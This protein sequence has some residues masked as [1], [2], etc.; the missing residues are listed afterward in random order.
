M[1][2]DIAQVKKA[3]IPTVAQ[4]ALK[5]NSIGLNDDVC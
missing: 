1:N 4:I 5:M 2:E 3:T